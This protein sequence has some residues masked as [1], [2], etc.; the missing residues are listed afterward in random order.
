[1]PVEPLKARQ[2]LAGAA[3]PVGAAAH[4]A[5]IAC[6]VEQPSLRADYKVD[7]G[8]SCP[9]LIREF[10]RALDANDAALEIGMAAPKPAQAPPPAKKAK[11]SWDKKGGAI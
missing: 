2:A 5:V 4:M 1:M 7:D 3:A 9:W 8:D 6:I 10:F 11:R